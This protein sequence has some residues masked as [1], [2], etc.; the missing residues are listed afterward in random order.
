MIR[1]M[2]CPV[3]PTT[4]LLS[5][6]RV[7][8]CIAELLSTINTTILYQ[9]LP[10]VGQHLEIGDIFFTPFASFSINPPLQNIRTRDCF[11]T[12]IIRTTHSNSTSYSSS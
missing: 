1:M 6:G 8:C 3:F 11:G 9:V 10:A 2:S 5:R 4:E 7:S 12:K